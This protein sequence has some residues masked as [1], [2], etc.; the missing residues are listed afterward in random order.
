MTSKKDT[1]R[2]INTQ[3]AP[4][5]ASRSE[6]A[7]QGSIASC[8]RVAE[9]RGAEIADAPDEDRELKG[10]LMF[11]SDPKQAERGELGMVDELKQRLQGF[12]EDQSTAEKS[13]YAGK[14]S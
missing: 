3:D 6:A 9:T 13:Q 11:P 4:N 8:A 10:Q 2:A 1:N 5:D 14:S 7:K 12:A